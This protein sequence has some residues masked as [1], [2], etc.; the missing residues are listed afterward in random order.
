MNGIEVGFRNIPWSGG[1]DKTS[2]YTLVKGDVG[3]FVSVGNSGS[4][5]VPTNTFAAGDI[6][7]IFNNTAN[8]INI[9]CNAVSTYVAGNNNTRTSLVLSNRGLCTAFFYSSNVCIMSGN[10]T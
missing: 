1:A 4:I 9:T 5:I 3:E 10:I 7:S 6:I 2:G 8:S